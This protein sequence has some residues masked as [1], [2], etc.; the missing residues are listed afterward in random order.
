[1]SQ[2]TEP[3]MLVKYRDAGMNTYTYFWKN[4]DNH[5]ISPFFDS[6][7]EAQDWMDLKNYQEEAQALWSDSCTTP[8]KT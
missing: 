2:T 8:R 7:R 3:A 5:T 4:S 6:E 1:M